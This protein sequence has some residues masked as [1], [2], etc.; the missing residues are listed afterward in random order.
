MTSG[1]GSAVIMMRSTGREEEEMAFWLFHE[2]L[3]S[4]C[5]TF[6]YLLVR[7]SPPQ[8][9]LICSVD[10]LLV[11]IFIW[12]LL[13]LLQ[14][15]LHWWQDMCVQR[16]YHRGRTLRTHD[17]DSE[18]YNEGFKGTLFTKIRVSPVCNVIMIKRFFFFFNGHSI[19]YICSNAC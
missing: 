11:F 8:A 16:L 2:E 5:K 19:R 10:Q 4:A 6:I 1:R 17:Q 13:F 15:L 3:L 14:I 7:M 18:K 12:A 9:L